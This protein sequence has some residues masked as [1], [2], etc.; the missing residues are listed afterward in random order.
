MQIYVYPIKSIR[1]TSPESLEAS[2]SGF[3]YDRHFMLIKVDGSE[4]MHVSKFTEMCLFTTSLSPSNGKPDT[5]IVTYSKD[6][7]F[8][9]PNQ[10]IEQKPL[11]VP[12]V[13]DVSKLQQTEVTMHSSPT[14]SY[15]MGESY[16]AWFSDRFGYQVKLLYIGANRRKVLG[17]MPPSAASKH[18]QELAQINGNAKSSGGS[19]FGSITSAATSLMSTVTGNEENKENERDGV[20]EGI[21]FADCAPYLVI[22]S[23]SWENAQNRLPQGEVMDISKFRPN[24]IVEG[25]DE[26]F[27]EDFWAEIEIGS[28]ARFSLTQNCARCNSLNI[29][30]DT[31]KVGEGEAGKILKKLQSDRRVDL[32]AKWSPIFGRYGFLARPPNG[33][34][35]V[36]I[37]VGDSV[38]IVKKLDERPRFGKFSPSVGAIERHTNYIDSLA[39]SQY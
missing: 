20:D 22:S 12:L 19:W 9:K 30:Y 33:A 8:D 38:R 26:E 4:N 35:S 25:A 11:E 18:R 27:E 10:K 3:P 14:V 21:S 15:D 2:F 5:V 1:G 31:G 7:T 29:D 17:N 23:K 28:E 36:Q 24:I 37:R 34:N 39:Q 32:G 13:P 16:N 6:H